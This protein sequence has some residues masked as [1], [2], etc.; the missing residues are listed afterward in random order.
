MGLVAI[1]KSSQVKFFHCTL[2]KLQ[3]TFVQHA[4]LSHF[5]CVRGE[6]EKAFCFIVD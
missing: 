6:T 5:M 3:L 2:N 1:N 4:M